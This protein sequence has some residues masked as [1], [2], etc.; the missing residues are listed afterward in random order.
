MRYT[1]V[2][3]INDY[4]EACKF[5]QDK[6]DALGFER[7]NYFNK[8]ADD[9]LSKNS[10]VGHGNEGLQYHHICEDI[11]PSL[12]SKE[13]AEAN[14]YEYQTAENM[15]Y[16]N[17]LE[18]AWLHILITE[19]NSQA[20]DNNQDDITGV[21]GVQWMLLALNSIMCNAD[22]S[23]Y[24]SKN[25]EGKGCSYNVGNIIT[26][27]R[28]AWLKVVNRFCT[29]AFI[30]QRL[31]KTPQELATLIC[32]SCKKDGTQGGLLSIY[33]DILAE[34]NSTKLFDW[35][36]NAFADLVNFLKDNQSALVY[37][38]TGGGKT[39]T[40]L[41]YLRLFGGKALVLGPGETIKSGW[42]DKKNWTDLG[43]AADVVNYQTFMNDYKTRDLS[44][45]SVVICDEAHHLGAERWG[46]GIR[47]ILEN[48]PEIKII[49]LT[50]TP[51]KEQFDGTDT[52]FGGRICYG[53]DLA[54]G[55][56][57]KN[58]WPFSY[59]SSIYK[60]EDVKDEFEQAGLKGRVLWDRLNIKLNETP[61][62]E[63][64]HR[65]MP[66]GQ[67]K[68]I[69]FC[70]SIKDIPYAEEVMNKYDPTLE[71]RVITSKQDSKQNSDAKKWF[72]ETTDKNVCLVTVSMVNEGAHYDGVNTLIMFRRTHSATLYL[73][74]LGRVV[75]TTKKPNPNGIVFD[76]TNNAE[77]L[78]YNSAVQVEV[79]SDDISETEVTEDEKE[80]IIKK[81]KKVIKDLSGTEV[82]HEDYTEDCVA[83]LNTLREAQNV[84]KQSAVIYSAFDDLK[85]A[86]ET[87]EQDFFYYDLWSNLETATGNLSI[88]R[89]THA[90]SKKTSDTFD[91][92]LAGKRSVT[93]KIVKASE[94]EKLATA[95]RTAIRR[96][97][98][99]GYI[100]F[101][102]MRSFD[103]TIR[104]KSK[105]NET[106]KAL[107]FKNA[108]LFE[109]VMNK[110]NKHSLIIASNI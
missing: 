67:R 41:E 18:H 48:K 24:S 109:D 110:L 26:D 49:G 75:V 17:L 81:V 19:N 78:I 16:A 96:L 82:I 22:T 95:F 59:I 104:N 86:L 2:F 30:R 69:V 38:C 101:A 87:E 83:T 25:E 90:M 99:F 79:T 70:S 55:I 45:Y 50:A 43:T 88:T 12:S 58:I 44:K 8:K 27:N 47:W 31:G 33:N 28:D 53:L 3:E 32:L 15:C 74:Q 84:N 23:W 103:I 34:A 13:R 60:M 100:E 66:K 108:K 89:P 46:E 36:V 39:T 7:L 10:K 71:C 73:Q 72:N 94:V 37:I 21:G 35:N 29:S 20:A 42:E 11:V 77:N 105:F 97:Y 54:T 91:E 6:Y 9:T 76:F 85:K 40:A 68:I 63:I 61:V 93:K 107:G 14:L 98:N 52:E 56:K 65:H 1:N 57:E 5:L 92:A 106:I 51:T 102:D 80:D 62:T 4:R 64:L